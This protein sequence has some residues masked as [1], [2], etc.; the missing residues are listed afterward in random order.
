MQPNIDERYGASF[1][2]TI[3]L[4]TALENGKT[5]GDGVQFVPLVAQTIEAYY[6]AGTGREMTAA[7]NN[8]FRVLTTAAE[9]GEPNMLASAGL[10]R[11][12]FDGPRVA[13]VHATGEAAG[14]TAR[15]WAELDDAELAKSRDE[16][17]A[18]MHHMSGSYE[19]MSWG[20]HDDDGAP[21]AGDFDK[22]LE[23][24]WRRRA[25]RRHD[26]LPNV[27]EAEETYRIRLQAGLKIGAE[28]F[29]A[30]VQAYVAATS[31]DARGLI[32][33]LGPTAATSLADAVEARLKTIEEELVQ[34]REKLRDELE[35][36]EL[37]AAAVFEDLE[38]A[39]IGSSLIHGYKKQ[40]RTYIECVTYL[41]K[42]RYAF[43]LIEAALVA[44]NAGQAAVAQLSRSVAELRRALRS[45][46]DH[47]LFRV[48]AL[49]SRQLTPVQELVERPLLHREDLRALYASVAGCAWGDVHEEV[50]ARLRH[51]VAPLSRWLGATEDEI[52]EDITAATMPVFDRIAGMSADD[53]WRW[54]C[55]R[56][57]QAPEIALRNFIALAPV[58]CRY[59]RAMLPNAGSLNERSFTMIGVP[60]RD[61]SFLAGT[62]QGTLVTTGDPRHIVILRL[63][64]GFPPS[65]IWGFDRHRAAFEEARR[66]GVVAQ[67]IYPG[68]PHE[69]KRPW[70]RRGH[71]NN[72]E[73]HAR[74]RRTGAKKQGAG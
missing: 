74:R 68:F 63:K 56:T 33:G 30:A 64:L 18:H 65:A 3:Y 14:L 23:A 49:E 52:R 61:A 8:H 59:D 42:V 60:D 5:A 25:P 69:L 29:D 9:N 62:Q 70:G 67:D 48:G 31:A 40:L 58:M 22:A 47:L 44:L 51:H 20:Q 38:Q 39:V 50:D 43:D 4:S 6:G 54:Q 19:L 71:N 73:K 13:R 21:L 7:A 10:L 66:L 46:G 16:A 41:F 37:T 55:E 17:A 32:D 2:A 53:A 34:Q 45:V 57:H 28:R 24:S 1:D 72:T 26:L 11:A 35:D 12:E 27:L 36:A 15:R